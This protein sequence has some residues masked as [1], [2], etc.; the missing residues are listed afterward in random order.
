[1]PCRRGV[2]ERDAGDRAGLPA[3]VLKLVK[4]GRDDAAVI[5]DVQ[6]AVVRLHAADQLRRALGRVGIGVQDAARRQ[7]ARPVR[8]IGRLAFQ[9]AGSL[10][11]QRAERPGVG[12]GDPGVVAS[13]QAIRRDG[14][15]LP[16]HV[17]HALVVSRAGHHEA[18]LGRP[19]GGVILE[20]QPRALA[21]GV[22]LARL[23]DRRGL[24]GGPVESV[25]PDDEHMP[26]TS[27][28]RVLL[29]AVEIALV[30]VDGPI[31]RACSR[32]RL[33]TRP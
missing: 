31:V 6:A 19:K 15:E 9:I 28:D 32:A 26:G 7:N 10:R 24:G 12:A 25:E 17:L 2:A 27:G 22:D 29:H 1:M 23:G 16:V 18:V 21:L 14:D 20:E 33:R 30:G 3:L 13:S 8:L 5:G 4:E 11:A